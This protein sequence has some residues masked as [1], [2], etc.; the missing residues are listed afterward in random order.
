MSASDDDGRLLQAWREIVDSDDP[1]PVQVTRAVLRPLVDEIE[2]LQ[3]WKQEAVVVLAQ[4]EDVYNLACADSLQRDDA[5]G[6][7]KAQIVAN[8]LV[9]RRRMFAALAQAN[10]WKASWGERAV[11]EMT[12][13]L[14]DNDEGGTRVHPDRVACMEALI[15]EWV[16]DGEEDDDA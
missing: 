1:L 8:E 9:S 15:S 5:L 12:S 4:W 10:G 14:A 16:D 7:W 11:A 6:R 2:R 13:V 3:R